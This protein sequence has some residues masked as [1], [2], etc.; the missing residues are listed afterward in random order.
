QLRRTLKCWFE[1]G[2]DGQACAEA[3]NIHRNSLRYRLE[4]IADISGV[5]LASPKGTTELYLAMILA[6]E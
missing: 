5:D 4:R 3:L 1:H 2:S 6:A